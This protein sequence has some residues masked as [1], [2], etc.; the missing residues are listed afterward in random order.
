MFQIIPAIDLLDGKVVRLIQGDYEKQ[1]HY[2]GDPVQV[3][4][5]F[6]AQGT[7]RL[8]VVDLDGAKAGKPINFQIIS[9]IAKKTNLSIDVGGGIR[10]EKDVQYYLQAGIDFCVLGSVL[11][12]DACLAGDLLELY[13][14]KIIIGLDARNGMVSASGWT[15]DSQTPILEMAQTLEKSGA[16]QIIATDIS[17]D[18]MLSGPSLQLYEELSAHTNLKIIASG[19]VSAIEDIQNLKKI[20]NVVGAIVG[21]ALYERKLDLSQLLSL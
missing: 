14:E 2:S 7:K 8:H 16:K 12:K 6:E 3:A 9:A 18:G 1:T 20:N 5:E 21:K 15:E 10:T 4:Q 13:G 19:G 17:R 11:L